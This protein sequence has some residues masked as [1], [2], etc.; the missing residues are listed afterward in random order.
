MDNVLSIVDGNINWI[1]MIQETYIEIGEEGVV[2]EI[3]LRKLFS[4]R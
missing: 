1:K 3:G 4:F 2:P